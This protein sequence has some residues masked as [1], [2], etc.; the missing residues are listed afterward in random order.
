M[1]GGAFFFGIYGNDINDFLYTGGRNNLGNGYYLTYWYNNNKYGSSVDRVNANNPRGQWGLVI[2]STPGYTSFGF[3]SLSDPQSSL[4]SR[5]FYGYLSEVAMFTDQIS[6]VD[7]GSLYAAQYISRTS[8]TTLTGTPLFTQLSPSATSSA[9]GAF[10]LR[11][12]NGT[13][14][15]AVQVRPVAAFPP[16]AMTGATT[17]LT[18]YPFGGTGSYV[19]SASSQYNTG[20]EAAWNAFDKITNGN[21][22]YWGQWTANGL[23]YNGDG[24]YNG[25]ASKTISGTVYN[26]EWIQIQMPIAI[27]ISSF[28]MY[29][30]NL[31]RAPKNFVLGG[32][33]DGATWTLIGT[34][35][36]PSYPT[37]SS[38]TF[39]V[40]TSTAYQYYTISIQ[41][42]N[43]SSGVQFLTVNE[44]IF[45]GS[46][47]SWQTDF[48]ADRLGNLLTAPVVGQTLA[49]WLGGAT[50][51]VTTWYDQSGR[52]NDASQTTAANQPIIQRA[53]KGA[54]YSCLFNGN[55]WVSYG[56]LSTFAGTPFSVVA[57]I[58][59]NNG[60]DRNAYAGTGEHVTTRTGLV[61]GFT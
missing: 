2:G 1:S 14:A 46:N 15:K 61:L 25:S 36:S 8:S 32:S 52:G 22:S 35:T 16:A 31:Q 42:I 38:N 43:N 26:G 12:V 60:N 40:S 55:Q 11:A 45:N 23:L 59:R 6:Q 56:T 27:V 51:Y 37:N 41:T 21:A 57:A 53:T 29:C 54:G 24:T 30:Q 19:V 7:A 39:S 9:V 50:G 17:S 44:I 48:Y 18:G 5:A 28:T 20:P 10:S 58:R 33:L 47:A 3:N 13:S 49:N 34:Y 4:T